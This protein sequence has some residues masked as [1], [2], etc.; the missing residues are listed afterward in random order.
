MLQV[1]HV[2]YGVVD[3][4]YMLGLG[5]GKIEGARV[6]KGIGLRHKT[7]LGRSDPGIFIQ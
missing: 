6:F 2:S 4:N 3:E 1:L 7:I 5:A